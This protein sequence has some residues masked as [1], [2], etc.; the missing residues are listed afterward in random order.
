[1]LFTFISPIL[2]EIT[3]ENEYLIDVIGEYNA[4]NRRQVSPAENYRY[5]LLFNDKNVP[6]SLENA[7]NV[8]L[9]DYSTGHMETVRASSVEVGETVMIRGA[10]AKPKDC[11]ILRN[12]PW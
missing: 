11:I 7:A 3:E 10:A 12:Y 1:M 4:A 9:Y 8:W 5:T 6:C 2:K